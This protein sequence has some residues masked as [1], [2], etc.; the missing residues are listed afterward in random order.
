[1]TDIE[2]AEAKIQ[3]LI[4]CIDTEDGSIISDLIA[5]A[6]KEYGELRD[7]AGYDR[8]WNAGADAYQ[9]CCHD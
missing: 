3:Q 4:A 7:E 5:E 6:V 8:G 1:M 2:K 9:P